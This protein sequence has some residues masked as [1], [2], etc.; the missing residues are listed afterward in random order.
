[1]ATVEDSIRLRDGFSPVLANIRTNARS[2]SQV[3]KDFRADVESPIS[4]DIFN[5]MNHHINTLEDQ[6]RQ[7]QHQLNQVG[8]QGR[9]GMNGV[10][11]GANMAVVNVAALIQILA[12]A[13]E[14]FKKF[15]DTADMMT[16]ITARVKLINDGNQTDQQL[17][18]MIFQ[19]AQR[20]RA[21]YEDT[22]A[23]ISKMGLLAGE[24]FSGNDEMVYF[25]ELMNKTFKV[26]G[27]SIMEQQAAMYQLTQA[28]AAGKLQGDEFRSIMENAPMLA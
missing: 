3:L 4:S 18:Q 25:A 15:T 24:A 6:L 20:A 23:A 10:S 13:N 2:A 7:T 16:S 21:S 19:S 28:M 26:G 9:K 8:E 27:S 22:A 11:Q 1:M 12:Q 14:L 17:D 5:Q